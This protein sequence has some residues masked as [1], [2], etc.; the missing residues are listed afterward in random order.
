M[1]D[2]YQNGIITTLHNLSDRPVEDLENGSWSQFSRKRPMGLLLPSLYSEL[3][4]EA[5]PRIST[6]WP[7]VPYLEQI[8]IGLDAP[9]SSSTAM[10]CSSSRPP[11]AAPPRALE[12]RPAPA[13]AGQGAG[14]F[15]L[16]P[17][18][19]G[20]GRNVWYCMGFILA[21]HASSPS[22]STTATSSP[23]SAPCWRA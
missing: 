20:K 10:R 18:E 22:R 23:T 1:A 16:A 7:C 17:R 9:M 13:R 14:E 11:A 5:L 21:A 15:D 6:T 3:E 12:R 2:F 19:E 4:G 8:V